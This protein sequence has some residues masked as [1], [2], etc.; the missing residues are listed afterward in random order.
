MRIGVI[1]LVA[2]AAIVMAAQP[3]V[4][5]SPLDGKDAAA[6]A[7]TA[8]NKEFWDFVRS[9][10]NEDGFYPVPEFLRAV[11][12][13][14]PAGSPH[15]QGQRSATGIDY[16]TARQMLI[17]QG[18][19]PVKIVSRGVDP[20]DENDLTCG[21]G[22]YRCKAYPE[23]REC[24]AAGIE[25]CAFLYENPRTRRYWIISTVGEEGGPPDVDF[26]RWRC[27]GYRPAAKSYLYDLTIVRPNGRRIQFPHS[28][29]P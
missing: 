15:V 10:I 24:S 4:A 28:P 5:A 26:R 2:F 3:G 27:C 29:K 23:L 25:Y 11:A 16:P 22:R 7:R 21:E 1:L 20:E 14:P 8:K 6:Q 17:R 9:R 18:F 12:A 19:L 13:R